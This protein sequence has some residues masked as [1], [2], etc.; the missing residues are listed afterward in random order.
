MAWFRQKNVDNIGIPQV[1]SIFFAQS[2]KPKM[3]KLAS[4]G[5]TRQ[6]IK[7]LGINQWAL[8]RP[9]IW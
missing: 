8:H 6:M 1:F 3:K 7:L 5:K 4:C 9:Y 2:K